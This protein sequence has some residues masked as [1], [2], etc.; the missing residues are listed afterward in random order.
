MKWENICHCKVVNESLAEVGSGALVMF[1]SGREGN[2][3]YLL[4]LSGDS[5][6]GFSD[7]VL[8]HTIGLFLIWCTLH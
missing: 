2:S 4:Q 5:L 1:Q 3:V 7:D 6:S 8:L